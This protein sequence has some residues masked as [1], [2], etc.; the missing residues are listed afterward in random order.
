MLIH[1]RLGGVYG[2]IAKKEKPEDHV[3]VPVHQVMLSANLCWGGRGRVGGVKAVGPLN[4]GD[5]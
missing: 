2:C 1:I 3:Y 4:V 5:L